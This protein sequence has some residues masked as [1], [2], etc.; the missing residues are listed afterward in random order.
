MPSAY[1]ARG[2]ILLDLGRYDEAIAY[3]TKSTELDPYNERSQFKLSE[4]YRGIGK[5][6]LSETHR[7]R[8]DTIRG[9]RVRIGEL[10]Q[11]LSHAGPG[12]YEELS[13]LHMRLGALETAHYWKQ[14][15]QVVEE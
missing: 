1:L 15:A 8:G 6:A 13:S 4:A 5:E 12:E 2:S 14:R 11:N 9:D 3:L 7:Q 10:M